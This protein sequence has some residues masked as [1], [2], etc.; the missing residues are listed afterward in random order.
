[1]SGSS[2]IVDLSKFLSIVGKSW[3]KEFKSREEKSMILEID[4]KQIKFDID[5]KMEVVKL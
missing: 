2:S 4:D 1:M 3:F 5:D